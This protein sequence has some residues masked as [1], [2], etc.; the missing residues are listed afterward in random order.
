MALNLWIC[1]YFIIL[2]MW[3]LVEQF[4]LDQW[5]EKNKLNFLPISRNKM[6]HQED[7]NILDEI[8]DFVSLFCKSPVFHIFYLYLYYTFIVISFIHYMFKKIRNLSA[9]KCNFLKC[10]N[11]ERYF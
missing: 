4:Y 6:I 7:K 8:L 10:K 2:C 11:M 9:K 1:I 5:E 3:F